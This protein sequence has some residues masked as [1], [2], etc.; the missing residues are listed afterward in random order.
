MKKRLENLHIGDIAIDGGR[1]VMAD[2]CRVEEVMRQL[3]K[4]DEKVDHNQAAIDGTDVVNFRK[5][6]SSKLNMGIG[7][8]LP[9]GLGDGIYPVFA[10]YETTKDFG[11]RITQITIVFSNPFRGRGCRNTKP[12][13]IVEQCMYGSLKKKK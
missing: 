1:L 10:N 4:R 9:T 7:V 5:A 6:F 2:P 8:L 3:L 13:K 12:H 11:R